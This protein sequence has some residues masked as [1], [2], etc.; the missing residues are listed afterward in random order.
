[1]V[2]KPWAIDCFYSL[3]LYPH[4]H[5][6]SDTTTSPHINQNTHPFPSLPFPSIAPLIAE[7]KLTLGFS[8]RRWGTTLR[9]EIDRYAGSE[10]FWTYKQETS[11]TGSENGG[12]PYAQRSIDMP[13]AANFSPVIGIE[14]ACFRIEKQQKGVFLGG[15]VLGANHGVPLGVS[16]IS[17]GTPAFDMGISDFMENAKCYFVRDFC[18]LLWMGCIH[19]LRYSS[20][21]K[22]NI[23]SRKLALLCQ[24]KAE[25]VYGFAAR[26]RDNVR[27]SLRLPA[28]YGDWIKKFDYPE[29]KAD[30]RTVDGRIFKVKIIKIAG[31][32]YLYNG[33]FDMVTSLKLP[34]NSWLVFQ[35]EEALSSFCLIYFYQEVSLAPSEYFYYQPGHLKDR[36]NCMVLIQFKL[37]LFDI[38]SYV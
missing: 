27:K 7:S 38:F 3:L 22:A 37:H 31:N 16:N 9:S 32:Y 23:C 30:I 5:H 8:D 26:L 15:G 6:H 34:C 35:F 36:D 2:L 20:D 29:K 13:C 4:P 21:F 28:L 11:G 12:R 14:E 1:M 19:C 33:W 10:T 25:M 17:S 18:F 24:K